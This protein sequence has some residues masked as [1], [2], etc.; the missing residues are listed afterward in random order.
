MFTWKVEE[1]KLMKE[2]EKNGSLRSLKESISMEDKIAFI[3]QMQNGAMTY[4]KELRDKLM[5]DSGSMPKDSFG[6]VKTVSLLAW[7]KRNDPRKL[8]DTRYIYGD[9]CL[10]SCHIKLHSKN[11]YN[12][13]GFVNDVFY[14][15][16]DACFR[17]EKMY[18]REHDE[19]EILKTKMQTHQMARITT[20]GVNVV[21]MGD[22]K[23]L[24]ENQEGERRDITIAE[25]KELI[26]KYDE[27]QHVIQQTIEKM[28]AEINI[29]Y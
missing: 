3:D 25:L 6:E 28:T 29:T 12:F 9:I 8:V 17:R 10:L 22:N 16:L 18:F 7:L 13:D 26:A 14:H 1:L 5:E 11:H 2:K 15:L 4:I 27:L 24:I 19:Y 21:I 23:V 20:F